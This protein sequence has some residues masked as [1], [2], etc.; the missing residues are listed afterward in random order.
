MEIQAAMIAFA[1]NGDNAPGY[2]AAPV[3]EGPYPGVVVIQE[4]WGL[5]D[6]IKAVVERFAEAGF[7]ALAPDLYRGKVTTEP[8][9]A[10]KLA[11][12]LEMDQAVK[13]IQGA[14]EYLRDL[15]AV[16]PKQI[17]VVGFCMGGGLAARMAVEGEHI[18]AV[19]VFYGR[20]NTDSTAHVRVP[21]LGLFGETDG[22]IPADGVRAAAERLEQE[23]KTAEFHIYPEAGHAFFNDTRPAAYHHDAAADA[24]QRT[25][26]WFTKHLT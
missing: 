20:I 18:G 4:W 23:G 7:V 9:E 17:G 22:G 10:R 6:H 15:K 16:A 25:L 8:D 5:T 2:L 26:D 1:A 24:W 12:E 14:A 11:M 13:D 21:L 3:E 19:V